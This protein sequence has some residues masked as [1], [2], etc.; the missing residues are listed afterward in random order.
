MPGYKA[1][2]VG[3]NFEFMVDDEPQYLEFSRTVYVDAQDE[4]E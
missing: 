1:T 4:M 3:E 2:V